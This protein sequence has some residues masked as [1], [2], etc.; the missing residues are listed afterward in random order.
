MIQ[1]VLDQTETIY[2]IVKKIH[3]EELVKYKIN[4]KKFR[5]LNYLFSE[6][7]CSPSTISDQLYYDRPTTTILLKQLEEA[8]W[9]LRQT[10]NLNRR[11]VEVTL[12]KEGE[13][14]YVEIIAKTSVVSRFEG[15]LNED[16]L[17]TLTLLL[18][19]MLA[20]S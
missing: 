16:E 3:Q 20:A 14:R 9:I 10:N 19:K 1:D 11:Y 5:I 6:K 13:H 18:N 7:K 15:S 17:A 12:T 4:H 8:G 2:Q